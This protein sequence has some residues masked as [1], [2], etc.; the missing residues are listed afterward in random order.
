MAYFT[1]VAVDE[2]GREKRG[3]IDAPN[4]GAARARL[5]KKALLPIS[6]AP[7][8]AGDTERAE[9]VAAVTGV[10]RAELTHKQ[11]LVVTRQLA[12]LVDAAVPVDEAL[13][14]IAA[15]QDNANARRVM[16]DVQN[17]VMEGLRLGEALGRHPKSFPGLYRAAVA[18]GE[19]AG[20]LGGVLTSLADYLGKE[21]ALRSK[22]TAALIYPAALCLV[23]ITVV[24]CLMI[25]VVPTLIEQ[26]KSFDAKL[27]LLT[28]ILIGVSWFLTHFWPLLIAAGVGGGL[29]GRALWSQEPFRRGLDALILAAPVTGARAREL[30]SSRFVRA[31]A[32]LTSSGLPVLDAVRVARDAVGN[33]IFRDAVTRMANAVEQGEPLSA[34]M[35]AAGVIPPMVAY[36][37]ASGENAGDLAGMLDKA[38]DYMDQEVDSFTTAALS[39]LEPAIIVFMGATVAGIVLA[40]MLPILQFNRMAIG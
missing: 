32:M 28:Q 27:P 3:G 34:A 25:F 5:Q 39:L 23:A 24:T 4:E 40:I 14:M 18:G 33:R 8:A 17:G 22:I 36:M 1:Y 38:A 12:A 21:Q 15:Q 26:F 11:R 7:S 30:T 9:R 20:Q 10:A 31:V 13:G 16:R 19:R 29:L 37:A 6:L 35:R 2:A